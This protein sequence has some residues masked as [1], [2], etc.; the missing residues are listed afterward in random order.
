[1]NTRKKIVAT[2]VISLSITHF[3]THTM[4]VNF[5]PNAV[6]PVIEHIRTQLQG[7]VKSACK[8][9]LYLGCG[10]S[11]LTI[12]AKTIVSKLKAPSE[13]SQEGKVSFR[14][15]FLPYAIGIGSGFALL[16]AGYLGL[17]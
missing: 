12:L 3:T 9:L 16:T 1:M 8:S 17:K 11:G 5:D 2:I 10:I 7:T 4:A 15:R 14:R 13:P 6:R